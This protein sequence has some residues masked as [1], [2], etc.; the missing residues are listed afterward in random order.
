MSPSDRRVERIALAVA[1]RVTPM[2]I[3]RCHPAQGRFERI[4]RRGGVW[5]HGAGGRAGGPGGARPVRR[6]SVMQLLYPPPRGEVNR[7][8]GP[9][10]PALSPVQ[11]S[12]PAGTTWAG[13]ESGRG[14]TS[15]EV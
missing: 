10:D 3:G 14:R 9:I 2:V 8:G 4:V 15:C 13:R 5:V 7:G 1:M 11:T 6:R 12:Q